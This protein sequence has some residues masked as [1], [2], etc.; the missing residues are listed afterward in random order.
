I[1]IST[2]PEGRSNWLQRGVVEH[3]RQRFAVPIHP[4]VVSLEAERY[5][6]FPATEE[7]YFATAVICAGVSVPLKA[8]ITLPPLITWCWTIAR[9]GFSWSRFGPTVPV[10]PAS[11]SVWQLPQFAVKMSLPFVEFFAAVT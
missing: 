7:T 11:A 9:G 4:V 10:V 2:H 1:V 5:P 8:G 6:F 3:A